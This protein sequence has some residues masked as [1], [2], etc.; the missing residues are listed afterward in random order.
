MRTLPPV[1]NGAKLYE[2]SSAI[3]FHCRNAGWRRPA[4]DVG[5]ILPLGNQ[6][7]EFLRAVD[8]AAPDFERLHH[9]ALRVALLV[10]LQEALVEPTQ[11]RR[12]EHTLLAAPVGQP[13]L[14]I[15]LLP[16]TDGVCQL[17]V[18]AHFYGF[19]ASSIATR[20]RRVNAQ[21]ILRS[22]A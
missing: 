13:A 14:L 1:G 4:T 8:G 21:A 10:Q 20:T 2:I 9:L 6:P 22:E 5:S 19:R 17:L 18:R 16:S 7:Q 12:A 15:A 11:A 3:F